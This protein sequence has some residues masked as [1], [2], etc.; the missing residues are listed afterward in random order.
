MVRQGRH[1][2]IACQGDPEQLYDLADDPAELVD[3]ADDPQHR[4]TVRELRD[5][6]ARNW[7]LEALEGRVL[8]SQRERQLVMRGLAEGA[9]SS[10]AFEPASRGRAAT[11]GEAPTSTRCSARRGSTRPV[12]LILRPDPTLLGP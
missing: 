5:E 8:A 3:L 7:E 4:A 2:F 1:K 11:S 10:W 12:H 6:V 9:A